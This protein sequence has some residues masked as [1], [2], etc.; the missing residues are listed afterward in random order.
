VLEQPVGFMKF[1]FAL[2][3]FFLSFMTFAQT[4]TTPGGGGPTVNPSKEERCQQLS[5][6]TTEKER[7]YVESFNHKYAS[8]D[9]FSALIHKVA[10][11]QSLKLLEDIQVPGKTKT[12]CHDQ[13]K[14][15][16]LEILMLYKAGSLNGLNCLQFKKRSE[17]IDQIEKVLKFHGI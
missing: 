11:S 6:E 13:S 3:F 5:D 7:T 12:E 15:K 10:L 14:T 9:D 1:K 16:L 4:H 2:P 8:E 17:Q